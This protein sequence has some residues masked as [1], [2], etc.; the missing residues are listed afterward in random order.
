MENCVHFSIENLNK[1][2]D[3]KNR[4]AFSKKTT[5]KF[6]EIIAKSHYLIRYWNYWHWYWKYEHT[7]ICSFCSKSQFALAKND[8]LMQLL[9][10]MQYKIG[11]IEILNN[12]YSEKYCKKNLIAYLYG[13]M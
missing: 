13:C 2:K 11:V 8:V 5:D 10:S 6:P 7:K 3:W 1:K 12:C 9:L 4:K